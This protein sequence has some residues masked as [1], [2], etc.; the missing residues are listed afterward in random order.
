MKKETINIVWLKRD[1]RL[2][3]HEPL[4]RAEQAGIPY[5]IVYFL[6]PEL[7]EYPDT[8]FRHLQ[9]VYHSLKVMNTTLKEFNRSVHIF[10]ENALTAFKFLHQKF[11]IEQ[12]F[13][14]QESGTQITWKRDKKVA[15]LCATEKTKWVECQRDGIIRGIKNRNNWNK[16]WHVTMHKPVLKNQYSVS[17]IASFEQPFALPEKLKNKL[18]IYPEYYQPAGEV[19]AWRYLKSFAAKR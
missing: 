13:S 7:I 10:Y 12:L 15:L 18:E 17:K 8:S 16:Q 19:N 4:F 1:L 6:E 14:Y 5:L 3:D 9:F 11:N 2:Q